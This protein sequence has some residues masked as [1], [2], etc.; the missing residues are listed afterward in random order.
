MESV[1]I[2]DDD[3][4]LC[5]M[6]RDYFELNDLELAM[7]H[8][9][10]AGLQT[11]LHGAFDLV[12]LDVTLPTM[13]GF[14]ILQRLRAESQVGVVLLT[15]RGEDDAMVFGLDNGADDYV[16]KPFNPRELLARMRAV[17]RRR[18]TGEPVPAETRASAESVE[19]RVT[20]LGFSLS[21]ATRSAQYRGVPLCLSRVEFLLLEAL[22]ESADLVLPR[23]ELAERIFARTYNPLDRSLDMLVSR[24]RRKLDVADNPG[25]LIKTIRSA[26]YVFALSR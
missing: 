11:A 17:L 9:G 19:K 12:I 13:D 7:C 24:L 8:D 5:T 14:E 21:A 25:A 26:G 15:S 1:L 2:V 20:S 18:R 6:L 16:P 22:L 3:V 10:L 4:G 23:E